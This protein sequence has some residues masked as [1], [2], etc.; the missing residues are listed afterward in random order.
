MKE[1][2]TIDCVLVFDLLK[3]A[4][5][6]KM[7]AMEKINIIKSLRPMKAIAEEYEAF[8][9][10]A[11]EKLRGDKHDDMVK[12]ADEWRK[13]GDKST[14]S[15]EEKREVNEYFEN[16]HQALATCLDESLKEVHEVDVRQIGEDA[17]FAMVDANEGWTMEQILKLQEI[18]CD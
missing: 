2:K 17:F 18:V 7:D 15:I 13:M 4:K 14:L 5:L 9:E 16:Y 12:K 1:L 11:A 6:G 10:S 3:S 8:R